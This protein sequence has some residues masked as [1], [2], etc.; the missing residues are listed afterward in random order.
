MDRVGLA[1]S[2]SMAELPWEA[3]AAKVRRLGEATRLAAASPEERRAGL[4]PRA[5]DIRSAALGR[6]APPSRDAG[7]SRR[8]RT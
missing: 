7:T 8:D 5:F 6:S 1:T 2:G 3:A 4:D